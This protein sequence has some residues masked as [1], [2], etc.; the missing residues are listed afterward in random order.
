MFIEDLLVILHMYKL[1]DLL[2]ARDPPSSSWFNR[3]RIST[4]K[5]NLRL[6]QIS[7]S[8]AHIVTTSRYVVP[9]G[10]VKV[11]AG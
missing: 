10:R 6:R 11:P 1:L 3:S 9:T 8:V 7:T 2:D 5:Q 4:G